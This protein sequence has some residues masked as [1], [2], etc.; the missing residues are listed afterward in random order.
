[1]VDEN[2]THHLRSDSEELRLVAPVDAVL[3]G[4]AQIGFVDKRGRLESVVS[5]LAAEVPCG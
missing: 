4:Q 3:L 2:S 5:P 1:V